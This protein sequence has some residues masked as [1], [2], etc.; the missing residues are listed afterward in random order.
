MAFG[1]YFD[2]TRCTGC[3]AC[4]IACKDV[5]SL[6]ENVCY[7][8]VKTYS[9]GHYPS[10]KTYSYSSS[11][12]HCENPAC[13]NVCSSGAF[14]RMAD[15]AVVHSAQRCIGCRACMDACPYKIPVFLPD[16]H[17]VGKCNSCLELRNIGKNPAC[18]DACPSR[19]LQFCDLSAL[20]E[21]AAQPLVSE[22][23]VLPSSSQTR[24]NLRVLP[25]QI[26]CEDEAVE[27][28]L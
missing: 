20:D 23:A 26:A 2:M 22:L 8:T 3:K 10:V 17:I 19:A 16:K 11:C 7:R 28:L 27:L 25:K 21:S 15:G 6:G 1:F 5:N 24:P 4:Q 9:V 18:V 12:N 13:L 14:S